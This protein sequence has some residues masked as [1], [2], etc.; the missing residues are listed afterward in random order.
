[1]PRFADADLAPLP[2]DV[3]VRGLV[4]RVRQREPDLLPERAFDGDHAPRA[5]K[6][7]A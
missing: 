4:G 5:R 3:S 6:A 1:V 2:D 7:G